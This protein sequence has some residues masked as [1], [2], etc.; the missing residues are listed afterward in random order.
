[1]QITTLPAHVLWPVFRFVGLSCQVE[2]IVVCVQEVKAHSNV[3]KTYGV[4]K[5]FLALL[6]IFIAFFDF[7]PQ[8]W[9]ATFLGWSRL[10]ENR[11]SKPFLIILLQEKISCKIGVSVLELVRVI[12]KGVLIRWRVTTCRA[13]CT[14]QIRLFDEWSH[15]F[16]RVALVFMLVVVE[17]LVWVGFGAPAWHWAFKLTRTSL[18][19][20]EIRRIIWSSTPSYLV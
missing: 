1:M 11:I 6:A 4:L 13:M 17:A 10:V 7:Y 18:N 9:T 3:L 15:L 5:W 19:F 14:L 20:W 12:L 8:S 2:E 16:F